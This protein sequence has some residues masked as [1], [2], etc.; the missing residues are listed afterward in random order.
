MVQAPC[1]IPRYTCPVLD[2]SRV[3]PDNHGG[4]EAEQRPPD[5]DAADGRDTYLVPASKLTRPRRGSAKR[6]NSGDPDGG[7]LPPWLAWIVNSIGPPVDW[8]TYFTLNKPRDRSHGAGGSKLAAE[9]EMTDKERIQVILAASGMIVFVISYSIYCVKL[10]LA[11]YTTGE[12]SH[13]D[14]L[15]YLWNGCICTV[16]IVAAS[17][18]MIAHCI[19]PGL[20]DEWARAIKSR[21][22]RA[23]WLAENTD[24]R[25]ER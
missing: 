10:K 7:S 19:W 23:G 3:T 1:P 11:Q 20:F 16:G 15:G 4:A 24:R 8:S 17:A 2:T 5:S 22:V 6:A 13:A 14:Y 25:G 21:L 18:A 9:R 12:I